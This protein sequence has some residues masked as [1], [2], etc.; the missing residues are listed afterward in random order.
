[1]VFKVNSGLKPIHISVTEQRTLWGPFLLLYL[2]FPAEKVRGKKERMKG[3]KKERGDKEKEE[4]S[5]SR[6]KAGQFRN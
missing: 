5:Y 3:K 1:M 6:F 4:I 2:Y